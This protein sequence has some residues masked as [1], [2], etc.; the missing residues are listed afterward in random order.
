MRQIHPGDTELG[1]F[2]ADSK[3]L[4]E[5]Q[6]TNIIK[7]TSSLSDLYLQSHD[8]TDSEDNRSLSKSSINQDGFSSEG[9]KSEDESLKSS[10]SRIALAESERCE[11]SLTESEDENLKSSASGIIAESAGVKISE[12]SEQSP[13]NDIYKLTWKNLKVFYGKLSA[14]VSDN[15]RVG[16]FKITQVFL[17]NAMKWPRY[18]ANCHKL[19]EAIEW[20]LKTA[21]KIKSLKITNQRT[22]ATDRQQNKSLGKRKRGRNVVLNVAELSDERS[23]EFELFCDGNPV[24]LARKFQGESDN[25]VHGRSLQPGNESFEIMKIIGS[26]NWKDFDEDIHCVGTFIQWKEADAKPVPPKIDE[27]EAL[28]A[29][30]WNENTPIDI[31][32]EYCK[33]SLNPEQVQ[34]FKEAILNQKTL[35][36]PDFVYF[37][38]LSV[39]ADS[40]RELYKRTAEKPTR[41]RQAKK[42]KREKGW[43]KINKARRDHGEEYETYK[44]KT[45]PSKAIKPPT[46][47]KCK[48]PVCCKKFTEDERNSIHNDYWKIESIEGKR[49][50][51]IAHVE[52]SEPIF[53]R[54]GKTSENSK[55]KNTNKYYLT[56]D[57]D[58]LRVC[59]SFFIATFGF[60]RKFLRVS[61]K[62][63][64]KH[65]AASPTRRLTQAPPNKLPQSKVDHAIAHLSSF[66]AV[67]SHYCRQSTKKIYIDPSVDPFG[68]L[69]NAKLY[70]LYKEKCDKDKVI[71][72]VSRSTYNKLFDK[73][74]LKIHR[75]KKDQCQMCNEMGSKKAMNNLTAEENV[76]WDQHL[77]RNKDV[78]KLKQELSELSKDPD[79]RMLCFSFDLEKVLYTPCSKVSVLYYKRKLSTYNFTIYNHATKDGYCYMWNES[80]ASR[81][82]NEV[83]SFLNHFIR[84]EMKKGQYQR[85]VAFSD[86]CYG[87]NKN[88]A[89]MA[90]FNYICSD[91]HGV[92]I[93]HYFV[94]KGHSEME[95]DSIHSTVEANSNHIKVHVPIEW[96]I[97]VSLA[98]K[99]LKPLKVI[100]VERS[101]I[102]DFMKVAAPFSNTEAVSIS[103]CCALRYCDENR[104]KV[105][106]K[107]N[108]DESWKSTKLRQCR[109]GTPKYN[110]IQQGPQQCY[111]DEKAAISMKKYNDLVALCNDLTI[112]T[113]HHGFYK[114]LKALDIIP[115]HADS[116]S[117]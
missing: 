89:S 25:M 101:N 2:H 79:S 68:K 104:V 105:E 17:N 75:P 74:N 48:E 76:R 30:S 5:N 110:D 60:S 72:P 34:R 86:N 44:G 36:D 77:Q 61:L 116:D 84:S 111:K 62:K 31:F 78:K 22:K 91:Y 33:N 63:M 45:V 87:Q 16:Q 27:K 80:I 32:D 21:I 99:N 51:L 13:A 108:F 54:W 14:P 64:G 8:S 47:K 53:R 65:G 82:S 113:Y 49:Q 40:F 94:E 50:F 73:L 23:V 59:Q 102:L 114:G 56:K 46:C 42:R 4:T 39:G 109:K 93:E 67:E 98:R 103:E 96:E 20:S 83:A 1:T 97:V 70:T 7:P 106:Y 57:G 90:M 71:S 26:D 117:D 19:D 29:A 38:K 18:D 3:E 6:V 52:E 15:S 85:I 24:F 115:D 58:Q 66:P 112:P 55:R 37:K 100:H 107:K 11:Q 41:T 81:G 92:T 9:Q 88:Q 35:D 43:K 10:A 95:C 69:S 28:D 12:T